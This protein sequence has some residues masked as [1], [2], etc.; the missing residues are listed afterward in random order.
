MSQ[1]DKKKKSEENTSD[2]TM[3][4]EIKD[5]SERPLT[6]KIDT[7]P[8]P[9]TTGEGTNLKKIDQTAYVEKSGK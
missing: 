2:G 4:L 6:D 5:L 7:E 8:V 1:H 9:S 3:K